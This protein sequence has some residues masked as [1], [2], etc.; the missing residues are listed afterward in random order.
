[1][2]QYT[3]IFLDKESRSRILSKFTIPNGWNPYADHLT[4][5]LGKLPDGLKQN[6]GMTYKL[7]INKIGISKTNIALGV[8]TNIDTKNKIPHITF[9][10]NPEGGKPYMSNQIT[11]WKNIKPFYVSGKLM[12]K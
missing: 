6:V 11:S 9:A 5:S 7:K 10:V 3:G 4:I 12:E 2:A 1:M 8:D